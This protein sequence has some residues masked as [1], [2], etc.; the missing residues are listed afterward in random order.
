MNLIFMGP[1]GAGKGTQAETL[2]KQLGIPHISTGDM[3][4]MAIKQGTE[5]GLKA[6]G[7]MD[8]GGLVPDAVT[9]GLVS[10]R[11]NHGDCQSGFLLDGFPRTTLQAAALDNIL[12]D[13]GRKIE[14]VI[15]LNVKRE[16]LLGRLSGR[17][18]CR[19]CG[20][21][22]HIEFNPP[23]RESTC[24]QCSGEVYQRSDDCIETIGNRLSV[25]DEQT[26]PLIAFYDEA[27]VLINIDGDQ[28][29]DKVFE[30]IIAKIKG[31]TD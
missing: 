9:T 21:T 8:S 30:A 10:E 31:I 5:L 22:Y 12:S 3:F 23:A 13:M 2:V 29:P 7:F 11:L 19:D 14:A 1:P 17:R 28:Q 25:Y 6:K 4:R 20:A 15:N 27:G 26:A 18:I 16:A 24:D